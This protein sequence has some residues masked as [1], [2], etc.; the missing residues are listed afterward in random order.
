MTSS[1]RV[2]ARRYAKALLQIALKHKR[3]EKVRK[4]VADFARLVS[5]RAAVFHH[6]MIPARRKKALA[7]DL[8]RTAAP[9]TLRFIDVL[10]DKKRILLLP[11]AAAEFSRLL[12]EESGKARARVASASALSP[13]QQAEIKKKLKDF[14][15]KDVEL[16]LKVDPALLG[17]AVVRMGD[18]VIDGSLSGRLSRL[19]RRLSEGAWAGDRP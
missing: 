5:E 9:E 15:G 8:L 13:A 18:W 12:D 2:V 7:K 11:L 1:D 14:S 3:Q 10:I 19:G 17:G 4:E 6:P 16:D